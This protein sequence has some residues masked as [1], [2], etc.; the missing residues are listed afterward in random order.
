MSLLVG[1]GNKHANRECRASVLALWQSHFVEV[2]GFSGPRRRPLGSHVPPGMFGQVVAAHE[3]AV[4]HVA[5]KLL[6]TGVR[7]AMAGK[8]I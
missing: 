8:L 1:C 6:L 3:T 4:T 7:P 2:S 5:D